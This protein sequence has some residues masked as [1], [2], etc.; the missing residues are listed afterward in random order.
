MRLVFI[1]VGLQSPVQG[2]KFPIVFQQRV[3][4]GFYLSIHKYDKQNYSIAAIRQE[5]FGFPNRVSDAAT[6]EVS[7]ML[8]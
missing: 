1:V 3:V 7:S 2:L 8:R 5:G 6:T 4:F